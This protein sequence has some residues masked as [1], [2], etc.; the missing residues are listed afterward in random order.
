MCF[1][2]FICL[3][4]GLY[5]Q[6]SFSNTGRFNC[7]VVN[8]EP[9]SC[10]FLQHPGL[11]KCASLCLWLLQ[12]NRWIFLKS[13]HCEPV[14][15]RAALVCHCSLGTTEVCGNVGDEFAPQE[16]PGSTT[17]SSVIILCPCFQMAQWI[18]IIKQT[19]A[20]DS[21]CSAVKLTAWRELNIL[22]E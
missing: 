16:L 11:E 19:W 3:P 15:I 13:L 17:L 4:C 2:L 8:T 1:V 21:L 10:C 7:S 9:V 6:S 20:R 5:D 12:V 14:M 22:A 18:G